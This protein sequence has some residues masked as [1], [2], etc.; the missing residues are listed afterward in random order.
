M[1][2]IT[3][4]FIFLLSFAVNYG[5]NQWRNFNIN[6]DINSICVDSNYL[7][8]ATAIDGLIRINI[9]TF[10]TA[11]FTEYNSDLPSN[12]LEDVA[13][14]KTGNLWL[15]A[16]MRGLTKYNG[17]EWTTYNTSN[18]GIPYNGVYNIGFDDNNVWLGNMGITKF[19]G[20]SWTNYNKSN[21]DFPAEGC[22][23]I[24]CDTGNVKWIIVYNGIVRYDDLNFT[25]YT[26]N[27]SGLTSEY[28][29][30][31][32]FDDSNNA[33][34][35]TWGGGLVKYNGAD[36]I[37]Y[38][39]I[40]TGLPIDSIYSIAIDGDGNKWL[41]TYEGLVKYD[42]EGMILY[43][44]SNSGIAMNWIRNIAIDKK[45]TKW[46]VSISNDW[47]YY[48]TAF[49]EDG[50]VSVEKNKNDFKPSEFL[51]RQN[52]PNP[53]NPNT[54]ISY[55]LS[56]N[57]NVQIKIF[58]IMGREVKELVNEYKRAGNYTLDFDGSN[59][60]SGVYIYKMNAGNY[61]FSR[62]MLLLK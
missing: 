56:E 14:D 16:T 60:S 54:L 57:A 53:Y 23:S 48:L 45:G 9:S 24:A 11:H 2:K 5:Q 12:Y 25:L 6:Q 26:K 39:L 52:Y 61:S 4:L 34:I 32:A 33:W 40:N 20:T 13:V 28:I 36:W 41:G 42:S 3:L 10:E 30:S 55:Q 49:N 62:K 44:S 21:S 19:D 27:N 37:N 59:L 15:A 58:D 51:L 18:S 22:L 47:K 43:D 17:W 35:G 46:I 38:N 29:L 8:I 31:I 1:K 50:L 7:W